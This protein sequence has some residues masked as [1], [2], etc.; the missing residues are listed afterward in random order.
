MASRRSSRPA[1]SAGADDDSDHAEQRW[2]YV[3]GDDVLVHRRARSS[4]PC[5]VG[6]SSACSAAVRAGPA[7]SSR[8]SR[9]RTTVRSCPS[10]RSGAVS[11]R[12]SGPSPA[13]PCSSSSG[14]ARIASA[15]GAATSTAPSSDERVAP[16]PALRT[17]GVP[18][19]RSG[20]HRARRA[21]RRRRARGAARARAPVPDPD[22][23]LS[24]RLRRAG[25]DARGGGAPRGAR[26]GR[27]R[28]S[29]TSATSRASRGRSRTR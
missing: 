8:P 5:G 23:Q 10:A 16:L 6:T 11:T 28:R 3:R 17:V 2:F 20:D 19:P 22:V 26:G 9:A 21:R 25:R 27:R 24:R 14:I 29:P 12:S 1:A 13:A 7:T 15:A 18:A 4:F